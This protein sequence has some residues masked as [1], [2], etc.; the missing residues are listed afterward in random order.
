M[1]LENKKNLPTTE[2][3]SE[4]QLPYS[5]GALLYAPATND[6]ILRLIFQEGWREP[7][8][9]SLCLEDSISDHSVE[10]AEELIV[11]T[12]REIERALDR[13]PELYLPKL[14]IR[15][16]YPEQIQDL[17]ERLGECSRFLTGFI[18]PKYS[19][20]NAEEFNRSIIAANDRSDQKVYLMPTLESTDIVM[21]PDREHRLAALR[22]K[23]DEIAPLILNIRVGG[24]DLCSA[25][26]IRRSIDETIYDILPVSRILSDIIATFSPDYV[27][28]GPVWEYFDD[29]GTDTAWRDGLL[30]ELKLDRLN[31]FIGK[32]VIH[33]SQIPVINKGLRVSKKDWEDAQS[34][35]NWSPGQ[36]EMV[37]KN[38]SGDRMNEIKVHIRWAQKTTLLAQLYG[39]YES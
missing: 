13:N 11:S 26:G 21:L 23:T 6:K 17:H 30:R 39:V 38:C 14:F 33:P 7:Y 10:L 37:V 9:A 36:P 34:I 27:V 15:V 32:T 22:E 24:N 3:L 4:S 31:G 19:L 12:F 25:F 2:R 16:R 8:S 28:S 29:K 35:L 5:L 18:A 20:S 1:D